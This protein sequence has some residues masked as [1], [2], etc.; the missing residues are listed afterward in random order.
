MSTEKAIT[1]PQLDLVSRLES[2]EQRVIAL[3]ARRIPVRGVRSF[4]PG[5]GQPVSRPIVFCTF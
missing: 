2:L 4:R 1:D 5:T 3:E